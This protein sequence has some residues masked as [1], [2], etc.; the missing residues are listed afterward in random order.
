MDQALEQMYNKPVKGHGGIVGLTR[1]K[2]AVAQH[3]LT[4]QEK[5]MISAFLREFCGLNDE[6]ECNLHHEFS[7]SATKHEEVCIQQMLAYIQ[8]RDNLF[9]L[10]NNKM[11]NLVTGK[12]TSD[13]KSKYLLNCISLR[14][15]AY[16]EFVKTRFKD[17][18]K[19][20]FDP[21]KKMSKKHNIYKDSPAVVQKDT[22]N[23]LHI[24]DI[25]RARG[26]WLRK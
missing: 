23:A 5:F 1:R 6:D 4:K 21:I 13:E 24:I 9:D 11:R 16:G 8:E 26:F 12:E 14:Q 2:E 3:D 18:E 19:S 7:T 25:A 20:L 22:N 10:L 17:K 15:Q